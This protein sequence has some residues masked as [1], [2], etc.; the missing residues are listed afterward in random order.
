[1]QL[2]DY[3][4]TNK[5]ENLLVALHKY[6]VHNIVTKNKITANST[7]ISECIEGTPGW[8]VVSNSHNIKLNT[9]NIEDCFK[10]TGFNSR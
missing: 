9:N 1:M 4:K 8:Q 7:A 6:W 5:Q 3:S 2:Y 10:R